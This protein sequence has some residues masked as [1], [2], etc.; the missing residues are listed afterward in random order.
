[1][2]RTT[3]ANHAALLLLAVL[4]AATFA[5]CTDSTDKA[6]ATSDLT[7]PASREPACARARVGARAPPYQVDHAVPF[8]VL[9]SL[10]VVYGN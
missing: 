4:L 10:L 9:S 5:G 3:L 6:G 2:R 7:V 1:M 8:F